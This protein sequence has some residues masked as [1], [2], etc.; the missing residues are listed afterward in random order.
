[1]KR[2][3]YCHSESIASTLNILAKS[4]DT[5]GFDLPATRAEEDLQ[6][7]IGAGSALSNLTAARVYVAKEKADLS[8]P[9]Q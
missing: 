8:C 1:V 9:T 2:R 7:A 3:F 5:G 4:V 6:L